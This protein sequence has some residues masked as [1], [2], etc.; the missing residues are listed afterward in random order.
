MSPPAL[1]PRLISVGYRNS[2][3]RMDTGTGKTLVAVML[4]R[5]ITSIP[6]PA[7]RPRKLVVF[8]SPGVDLV[9]RAIAHLPSLGSCICHLTPDAGPVIIQSKLE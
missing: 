6:T 7:D 4:I 8:L 5:H 2:I 1:K 9:R 3:I